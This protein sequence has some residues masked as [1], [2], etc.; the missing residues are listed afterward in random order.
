MFKRK[1]KQQTEARRPQ[2]TRTGSPVFSYSAQRLRS[3]DPT[4]RAVHVPPKPDR[5]WLFLLPSVISAAVVVVSL[6]YATT[7]SNLPRIITI[8][9]D[10]RK[11]LRHEEYY[12][13]AFQEI[14]SRSVMNLSKLTINTVAVADEIELKYPELQNVSVSLPLLGR[15]P[16]VQ[17]QPR[18]PAF[19]IVSRSGSYLINSEGRAMLRAK[20]AAIS[21]LGL[22]TV[23]DDVGLEISTGKT[24]LPKDD[25]K[26]IST[27]IYQLKHQKVDVQSVTLPS[28]SNELH[29]RLQGR[30]YYVKFNLQG[31]AIEQ[32]GVL[33]AI[34]ERLESESQTPTEYIDVRVQDRAYVK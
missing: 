20:D 11:L 33:L 27:V 13:V 8:V 18:T 24:I 32:T 3:E 28:L 14:L 30:Q 34:K 25:I 31:S 6:I 2:V 15:K 12:Q 16:V 4:E 7:L 19:I 1:H 9:D 10:N 21:G 23:T 26:F 22:T 17:I 5:N 29:I